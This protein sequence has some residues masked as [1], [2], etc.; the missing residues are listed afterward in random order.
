[1]GFVVPDDLSLIGWDDSLI[2]RVVHPPLTAI[3]RDIEAYGATA[4]RHLL[5]VIDGA[6]REDVE[7][8]A[9]RADPARQHRSTAR[10]A[11]APRRAPARSER[12]RAGRRAHR[13]GN[14]ASRCVKPDACECC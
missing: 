5:A 3:T 10:G 9:G 7:V 13:C 11:P 4:A 8:A 2:S 1:M 12:R 6:T 14:P